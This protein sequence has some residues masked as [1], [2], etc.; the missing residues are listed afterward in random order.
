MGRCSAVHAK[1][2]D[3][4]LMGTLHS[5]M[6]DIFHLLYYRVEP[7]FFSAPGTKAWRTASPCTCL[8]FRSDE[9]MLYKAHVAQM[10]ND[11][12]LQIVDFTLSS[13]P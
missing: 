6:P 13:R 3:G 1:E 8:H 11:T 7:M 5:I 2:P 4:R 9:G 12:H 10:F